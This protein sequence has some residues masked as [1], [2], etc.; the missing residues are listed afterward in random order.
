MFCWV[1]YLTDFLSRQNNRGRIYYDS[2]WRYEKFGLRHAEWFAGIIQQ[3]HSEDNWNF[4]V[5]TLEAGVTFPDALV[6][7]QMHRKK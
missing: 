4:G 2:H 1:V 5:L 7:G 3:E 6:R